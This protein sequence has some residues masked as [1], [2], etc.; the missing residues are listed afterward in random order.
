VSRQTTARY[1]IDDLRRFAAALG[2]AAGLPRDKAAAFGAQLL[3]FDAAG[4][5]EH[6]LASLPEWLNRITRGDID[7]A[8]QGRVGPERA[9][10]ALFDAQNGLSGL[11]FERAAGIAG[12]KARDTGIGLVRVT[13]LGAVGPTAPIVAELAV[14]PFVG[15]VL[16]SNGTTAIGVPASDGLPV[17]FDSALASASHARRKTTVMFAGVAVPWTLLVPAGGWLVVAGAVSALESLAVFHSR[18][19]SAI[20]RGKEEPGLLLPS[21]WEARRRA[22]REHGI[23]ISAEIQQAFRP[24]VKKFGLAAPWDSARRD[25]DD[26]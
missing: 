17:V 8:A 24:W 22:A 16:G 14:G 2:A 9:G 25:L 10:V 21:P 12:E 4:A 19:E 23:T 11:L 18:V 7:P 3:W 1:R 5:S 26:G 15:L 13:G 20:A 6:G